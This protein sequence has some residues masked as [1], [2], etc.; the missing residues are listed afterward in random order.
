LHSQ[1]EALATRVDED[2]VIDL[3]SEA[4]TAETAPRR[5]SR[6]KSEPDAAPPSDSP[7]AEPVSATDSR[8]TPASPDVPI[9]PKSGFAQMV[10]RS[11]PEGPAQPKGPIRNIVRSVDHGFRLD[12]DFAEHVLVM[13]FDDKPEQQILDELKADGWIYHAT[14]KVWTLPTSPVRR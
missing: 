7:A 4:T 6:R 11:R 2:D 10:E 3:N 8:L 14:P 12:K 13:K 9:E 1:R 5:T